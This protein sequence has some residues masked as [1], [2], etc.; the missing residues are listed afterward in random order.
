[1]NRPAICRSSNQREAGSIRSDFDPG[2]PDA[3]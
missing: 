2:R 3:P 1:M